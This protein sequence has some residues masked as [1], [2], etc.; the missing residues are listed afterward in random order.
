M[1]PVTGF[2]RRLYGYTRQRLVFTGIHS[3][4]QPAALPFAGTADK[5]AYHISYPTR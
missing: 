5:M 3:P 2:F 1:T 4:S